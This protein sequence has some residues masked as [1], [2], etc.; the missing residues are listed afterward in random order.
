MRRPTSVSAGL[1]LYR[2]L[3][4]KLEVF[5]VHPGGPFWKKHDRGA[6]SIPKGLV[7]V[8]EE[9][10]TAACREFREETSFEPQAPYL[11]LGTVQQRGGKLI[12]AWAYEGNAD[13]HTL[14]SNTARLELP[15]GSGQWIEFPE[16]DR[17]DWFPPATARQKLNPA[18]A[19][20]IDRLETVLSPKNGDSG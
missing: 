19:A 9:L 14:S 6:W 16:I 13:P 11:A 20:F 10:L 12:H 8:G 15:P 17:G 5:L 7:A 18:Q 1:L 3:P 4:G 2:R